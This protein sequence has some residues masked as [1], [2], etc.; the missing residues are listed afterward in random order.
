MCCILTCPFPA[1]CQSPNKVLNRNR[2]FHFIFSA[3]VTVLLLTDVVMPFFTLR[4]QGWLF[5]G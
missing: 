1:K 5:N 2:N 3:D 4:F